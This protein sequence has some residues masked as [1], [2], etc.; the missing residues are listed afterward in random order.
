MQTP[1]DPT[2]SKYRGQI[3]GKWTRHQCPVP[4]CVWCGHI[5]LSAITAAQIPFHPGHSWHNKHTYV[6][7]IPL[8]VC[9]P[10]DCPIPCPAFHTGSQ[11]LGY[12]L[13]CDTFL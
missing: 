1:K 8:I 7:C 3:E 6:F 12:P 2:D 13:P 10:S 9:M 11:I 5:P 4:G